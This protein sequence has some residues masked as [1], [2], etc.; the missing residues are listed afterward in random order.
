MQSR[1]DAEGGPWLPVVAGPS[2]LGPGLLL[3]LTDKL[4][5]QIQLANVDLSVD[6]PRVS[7]GFIH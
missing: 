4:V 6:Y 7:F 2:S 5:S 3:I 1:M